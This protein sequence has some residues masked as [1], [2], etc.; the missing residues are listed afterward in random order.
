MGF[1]APRPYERLPD[2]DRPEVAFV[3]AG[4]SGRV[5]G[6]DSLSG[7]VAFQEWDNTDDVSGF[8]LADG[9]PIVLARS[10]GHSVTTRWFGAGK[11]RNHAEL[12]YFV[13]DGGGAVFSAS[14]M[15]W[16]LCLDREDVAQ[17]TTNVLERFLDPLPLER[18][19]PTL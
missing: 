7:G 14:S 17:I 12:T 6:D 8:A 16:C 18:P 13:T 10:T 5:V 9:K 15:A 2:S 3:F 4:V 11:R 1:D 19:R